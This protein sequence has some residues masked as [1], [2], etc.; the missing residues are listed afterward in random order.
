MVDIDL[1]TD[2]DVY[3][4]L[5]RDLIRNL[6]LTEKKAREVVQFLDSEGVIDYD[7]LKE[8][9]FYPDED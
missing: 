3:L 5:E 7:L 9:Y 8:V 1:D 4:I 6:D 2:V